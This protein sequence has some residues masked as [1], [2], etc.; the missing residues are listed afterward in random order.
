MHVFKPEKGDAQRL[1][2]RAGMTRLTLFPGRVDLRVM[3]INDGM[4]AVSKSYPIGAF[5]RFRSPLVLC[6]PSLGG[7]RV[8]V[9][10]TIENFSRLPRERIIDPCSVPSCDALSFRSVIATH[11][12]Q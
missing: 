6:H 11:I 2:V 8:R 9:R 10:R 4:S 1:T 12:S 5:L 7:L 3:N